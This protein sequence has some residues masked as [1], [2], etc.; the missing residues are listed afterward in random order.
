MI[1]YF[2]KQSGMISK[3]YKY[4]LE[5]LHDGFLIDLVNFLHFFLL[6]KGLF[7]WLGKHLKS[8]TYFKQTKLLCLIQS[9]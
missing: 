5:K 1:R 3:F 6:L 7:L 8:N 9:N 2:L 4:V